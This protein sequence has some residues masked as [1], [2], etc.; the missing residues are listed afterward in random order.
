MKSLDA[1][2]RVK[3]YGTD[4][5]IIKPCSKPTPDEIGKLMQGN[6]QL[7][8]QV[9]GHTDS[10]GGDAHNMDL[11]SRRAACVTPA[12]AGARIDARRFTSRGAS[13]S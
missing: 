2:G 9:V 7:H 12:L 6:L 11:S 1:T 5:D 4:K 13:A 10:T 8:L 3:L